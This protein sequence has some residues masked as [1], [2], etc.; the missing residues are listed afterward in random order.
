VGAG[1]REK[2]RPPAMLD[3][4]SGAEA[5][6][7]HGTCAQG[8]G[9][10]RRGSSAGRRWPSTSERKTARRWEDGLVCREIIRDV[11]AKIMVRQLFR[12]G[13]STTFLNRIM[14]AHMNQHS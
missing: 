13:G 8:G 14:S 3:K 12:D 11:F 4:E 9:V 1:P 5:T 10:G 7:R 2:E 6:P